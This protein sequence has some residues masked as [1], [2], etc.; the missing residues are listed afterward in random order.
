[1]I[2]VAWPVALLGSASVLDNPWNV[3]VSRAAE[4]GEHLAE[5]LLSRSHGKRPITLIG[6]SLGAR[7]IYHC[8]LA[9]SKRDNCLGIH[10]FFVSI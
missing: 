7:V 2:A 1:M 4:V 3:C 10:L 6:F 9:M 8:L 5:I